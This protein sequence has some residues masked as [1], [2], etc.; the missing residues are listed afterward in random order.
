M[1]SSSKSRPPVGTFCEG[2]GQSVYFA[3]GDRPIKRWD[4]LLSDYVDAGVPAPGSGLGIT[5]VESDTSQL[6]GTNYA[7]QR[8]L[9]DRG[10]VSNVSYIGAQSQCLVETINL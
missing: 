4:G 2:K 3:R 9:D 7:Y 8:W 10:N 1:A 5:E 6:I